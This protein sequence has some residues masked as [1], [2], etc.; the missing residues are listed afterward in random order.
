MRILVIT[1]YYLPDLGPS[2]PLFTMLSE[3]LVKHGH[4]VIVVTTVPHYPSGKVD[5]SFQGKW[6]YR[7]LERGVKI[8]R[9]WLPSVNRSKYAFRLLQ[10]LCYQ[11]GAVRAEFNQ[12]YDVVITAN[13]ALWTWLPFFYYVCLRNKPSVFSVHDVYPDVGVTLGVFHNRFVIVIVAGLE[14]YCLKH[15]RIVRILSESFRIGLR[16]LG[17]PES[18]MALVYDWVDT[19]LIRPL[20][21]DNQFAQT[22]GLEDRFV[23]LYAGNIGLSQGLEIV[24][25]AAEQLSVKPDVQFLFVGDGPGRE[26][27][28]R[29]VAL[30]KLTNVQFV[31]FQSRNNLPE[32]LGSADVSLVVLR[33]GIGSGSLPSKTFSIL[34]SGRPIIASVDKH[35]ETWDLIQKAQAGLCIEP[36]NPLELVRAILKLKNDR[37][38]RERLG[39]NGRIWAEKRHSSQSAT[40]QFE[41]LLNKAI[42]LTESEGKPST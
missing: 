40:I 11:I 21:R 34:A 14:R 38:L 1:P 36:E 30:C 32:V 6:I 22:Y 20:S 31:P 4:D 23:V 35:S 7:S 37:D 2:A 15:S 16:N 8:S 41:E 42:D 29:Q 12:K 5:A 26:Q 9:V 33:K 24:L 10:F 28:I 17:T 39:Q 25:A 19:E 13:P 27:L 18:K 3:G